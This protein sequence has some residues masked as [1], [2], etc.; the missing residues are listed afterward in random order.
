M[1]R[2]IDKIAIL[3]MCMMSLT[4]SDSFIEPVILTLAAVTASAAAQLL[5]G[6][7]AASVIIA[8]CSLLC[9]AF[10]LF[11][12]MLPLMLYDAIWEKNG[13]W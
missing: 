12:C 6:R 8:A 3:V 1:N 7:T 13:G 4:L 5:T 9:G 10:P 11:L 2:L